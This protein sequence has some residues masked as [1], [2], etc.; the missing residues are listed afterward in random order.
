MYFE[1]KKLDFSLK[2]KQSNLWPIQFVFIFVNFAQDEK[3]RDS[4]TLFNKLT[5][6]N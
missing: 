1:K 3:K 4:Q 5:N 6:G 2:K